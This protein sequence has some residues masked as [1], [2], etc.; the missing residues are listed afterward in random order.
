MDAI[1]GPQGIGVD[2]PWEDPVKL[3][4]LEAEFRARSRTDAWVGQVGAIDGCHFET[5]SPGKAVAD[6]RAYHVARK[7]S[8]AMLVTA[9][10]DADRRFTY[11]DFG[12]TPT[13]HDSTAFSQSSL[14]RKIATKG[15]PG[16][17]FLNG[18]SAYA[19]GPHMVVPFGKAAQTDFDFYQSSNRM[20][21]E[22]AFGVLI[23]RSALPFIPPSHTPSHLSFL[24]VLVI[25][26][27]ILWRPLEVAHARRGSLIGC[28]MRLHNF[29][30]DH[31]ISEEHLATM[32]GEAGVSVP[33]EGEMPS[34]W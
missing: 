32:N 21:I 30:I 3:A 17:F 25:R 29:C 26:W 31:R 9:V 16:E 1:S 14:G 2:D 27:G 15:L 8:F 7:K 33:G 13:T 19:V 18:D 10:C 24:F 28:L 34:R 11:W 22:C 12:C 4:V 5:H 23:R 6:P 20:A